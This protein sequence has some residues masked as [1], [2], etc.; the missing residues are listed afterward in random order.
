MPP[1]VPNEQELNLKKRARRRLVGA[2]VIVILMLIILP[3]ILQDRA[4]L[5]PPAVIK[6]S[7]PEAGLHQSSATKVVPA[8]DGQPSFDAKPA[9]SVVADFV[10]TESAVVDVG[11]SEA[12]DQV[13]LEASQQ[14]A[15]QAKLS[16]A[17]ASV[18]KI[19]ETKPTANPPSSFAVQVGVYSDAA[20]VVQLQ[21]KL[22][23]AGF[24]SRTEKMKTANGEKIR[25]H[26]GH[27][28][29]RQEATAALNK[30]QQAGFPG[31]VLSNE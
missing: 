9:R 11:N 18:A 14:K 10:N 29:S 6:I 12:N 26:M 3:K 22:S 7:M 4:A 31:M 2:I 23:Q 16:A 15:S 28:S 1:V 21:Q 27:F 30:L 8:V 20:N 17:K 13:Q 19:A 24:N 5:V 25:L